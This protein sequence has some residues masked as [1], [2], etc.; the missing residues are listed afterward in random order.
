MKAVTEFPNYVLNKA[1]AAKAAL[2]AEGKTPEEIQ[3][4]LGESFK[5]EG[6][7]LNYF[8][9]AIEVASQ[10]AE[11]L[12]RVLVMRLGEGENAPAKAVKV[13]DIV[14]VP[15]GIVLTAYKAPEKS[16]DGKRGG[17]GDKPKGSPWGLSPEEQAEKL[18]KRGAKTAAAAAAKPKA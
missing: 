8:I 11:G 15:E 9:Q 4:S 2:A 7:K 17:R 18:A 6:D 12:K 10:N 1:L 3:A 5:Y 16:K 13:E 14:Y